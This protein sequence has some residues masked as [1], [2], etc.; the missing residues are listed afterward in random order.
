MRQALQAVDEGMSLRGAAELYD[1]PR[2]TLTNYVA[3]GNNGESHQTH[4]S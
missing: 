3:N 2:S 4:R 1:I